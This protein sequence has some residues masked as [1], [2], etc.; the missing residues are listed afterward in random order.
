MELFKRAISSSPF[1]WPLRPNGLYIFNYHRIGDPN[2]NP[3]DPN[4]FSCTENTFEQHLKFYKQN[5]DVIS[6]NDLIKI[7]QK[8]QPLTK[9]Y[10][11]LTFDDGYID[12]YNLAYPLLKEYQLPATFYIAT[13]FIDT[14]VLPWWDEVAFIIKNR[15]LKSLTLPYLKEDIALQ[16]LSVAE[17]VKRV[18]RAI[19]EHKNLSMPK[20]LALLKEATQWQETPI[21]IENLFMNWQQV[22]EMQKNGM[23]IGSQTC[24]HSMLAHLTYQQQKQEIFQ[25]KER[26][27]KALSNTISSIA[28]PVGGYDSYNK[29]TLLLTEQ[30]GYK[31]G[32]NF[33]P[34]INSSLKDIFQLKRFSVDNDCSVADLK[35]LIN[36][37]VLERI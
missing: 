15:E 2:L 22:K 27:E 10:A 3:F 29:D 24:S 14:E 11:L 37:K 28:Y 36:R 34:G 16:N 9:K 13:D 26:L 4:V 6:T 25:S 32:F 20:K 18:L 1:V 8:N 30:A 12:N 17:Q 31:L 7:N 21:P 35:K 5:F 33:V 23:Y 19:K